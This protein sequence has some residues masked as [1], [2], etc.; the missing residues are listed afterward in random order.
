MKAEYIATSEAV[1]EIFWFKKFVAELDVMPSD[2]IALHCDNNGAIA[3][4]KELRFYQK[5]KHI[6]QWFHIIR[7]Y[8]EK[9]F[10][11]VQRVD[12]VLNVTDP[13]TKPLSQQKTEAHLEKMGLRYM[14]NWL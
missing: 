11:E 12:S 6:K 2:A 8:L 13:L 7:E 3:L 4:A 1:K 14:A 5:S 10:I 9:K